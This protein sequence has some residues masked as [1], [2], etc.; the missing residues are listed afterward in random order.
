MKVIDLLNKIGNQEPVPDKILVDGKHFYWDRLEMFYHTEDKK[1]LLEVGKEYSTWDF[2]NF[3]VIEIPQVDMDTEQ[4]DIKAIKEL[5]VVG[6]VLE[7]GSQYYKYSEEEE[8]IVLKV[9]ELIKAIKQ[10]DNK[11]NKE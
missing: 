9:N 7:D 5:E 2:L 10:L 6:E 1:D 3:N 11:I 8:E 4:I